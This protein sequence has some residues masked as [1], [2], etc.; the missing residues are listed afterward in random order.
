MQCTVI[1]CE[2]RKMRR[3]LG[4]SSVFLMEADDDC[5][6]IRPKILFRDK[7]SLFPNQKGAP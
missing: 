4:A 6:Q 5:T 7:L 2:G 3:C 1:R